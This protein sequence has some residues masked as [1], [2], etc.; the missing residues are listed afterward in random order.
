[1]KIKDK[2]TL[3]ISTDEGEYEVSRFCPHEGADLSKGYIDENEMI[4]CPW[5]HLM[6]DPKTG[7]TPCKHL[8]QLKVKNNDN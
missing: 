4:R 2:T 1:M 6:I 5:H 8:K 7:K 3:I